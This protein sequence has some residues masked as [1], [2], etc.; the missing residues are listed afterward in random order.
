MIAN[1]DPSQEEACSD[2]LT[3]CEAGAIEVEEEY[4]KIEGDHHHHQNGNSD[5]DD[6]DNDDNDIII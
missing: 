2:P 6:I 1:Q 4:G 5:Q 3:D